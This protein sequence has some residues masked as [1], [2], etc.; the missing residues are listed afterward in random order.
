MFFRPFVRRTLLTGRPASRLLSTS[1]PRRLFTEKEVVST[2]LKYGTKAAGW[3]AAF[4]L[5]AFLTAAFAGRERVIT[6][7]GYY[8]ECTDAMPVVV[9]KILVDKTLSDDEKR[10]LLKKE[11]ERLENYKHSISLFDDNFFGIPIN[12]RG[13]KNELT[14]RIEAQQR[15]I[16]E[17]R[18]ALS[19]RSTKS[20]PSLNK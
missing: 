10:L 20:G 8:R 7:M 19:G 2:L 5:H 11:A 14:D 1:A 13:Y 12:L 4:G 3:G 18:S 16:V 6:K 9:G 17:C 15:A